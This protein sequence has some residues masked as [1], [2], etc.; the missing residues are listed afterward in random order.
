MGRIGVWNKSMKTTDQ[1]RDLPHQMLLLYLQKIACVVLN[2]MCFGRSSSFCCCSKRQF[3]ASCSLFSLF[4]T[5]CAQQFGPIRGIIIV[6]SSRSV[7]NIGVNKKRSLYAMPARSTAAAVYK[8]TDSVRNLIVGQR[9]VG[10][11]WHS[12][13]I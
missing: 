9:P 1:S 5:F 8:G 2:L 3:Q 13:K 7:Q 11:H 10:L 6:Y 12:A 4:F